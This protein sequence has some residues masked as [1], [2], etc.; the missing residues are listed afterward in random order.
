MKKN[1]ADD[2]VIHVDPKHIPYSLFAHF[3]Q[4]ALSYKCFI[5]FFIHGTVLNKFEQNF[6]NKETEPKI[7]G[8]IEVFNK[9]KLNLNESR[10]SYD[11]GVTFIWKDGIFYIF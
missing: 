4:L 3:G 6:Y 1:C 10:S 7:K 11:Y 8:L 9:L 2:L 5:Q